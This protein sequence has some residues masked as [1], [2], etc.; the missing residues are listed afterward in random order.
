MSIDYLCTSPAV[1]TA[2]EASRYP[3]D[4]NTSASV[5]EYTLLHQVNQKVPEAQLQEGL[6]E[7][8]H[9]QGHKSSPALSI[10]SQRLADSEDISHQINSQYPSAER[11]GQGFNRYVQDLPNPERR[12]RRLKLAALDTDLNHPT[13]V[14]KLCESSHIATSSR[15]TERLPKFQA[16]SKHGAIQGREKDGKEIV[17]AGIQE[18][19]NTQRERQSI[20]TAK[21]RSRL[22]PPTTRV[23]RTLDQVTP[24]VQD[25]SSS[26]LQAK[27]VPLSSYNVDPT[28]D[29]TAEAVRVPLQSTA[30]DVILHKNLGTHIVNCYRADRQSTNHIDDHNASRVSSNTMAKAILP[31]FSHT[32]GK[33][34]RGD[35]GFGYGAPEISPLE[36]QRTFP[37]MFHSSLGRQNMVTVQQH[38][39]HGVRLS[40]PRVKVSA[41]RQGFLAM[42]NS[43]THQRIQPLN[44]ILSGMKKL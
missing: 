18:F 21:G 22:T 6:P 7:K 3:K 38:R 13:E 12:P 43:V 41:I 15:N 31:R 4:H 26:S 30:P 37:T 11:T 39:E 1:W 5:K 17:E 40:I 23:F 9:R 34:E 33:V 44:P 8:S 16:A 42:E 28:I 25:L 2:D 36:E 27:L 10:G 19:V 29:G 35:P 14:P 24:E 32:S 20:R